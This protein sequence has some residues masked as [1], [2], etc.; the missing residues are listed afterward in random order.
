MNKPLK[1]NCY[2]TVFQNLIQNAIKYND[3]TEKIID[4]NYKPTVDFHVFSI[5]DNGIGIEEKYFDKIFILF[6]KLELNTEKDSIGIG[7]ALVKKIINTMHGEVWLESRL[8]T[9]IIFYFTLPK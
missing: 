9:G 6:Q 7:L 8:E 5:K 2:W 1:W 3:K 4:I